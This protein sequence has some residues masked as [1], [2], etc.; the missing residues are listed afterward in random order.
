MNI[1]YFLQKENISTLWDVIAYESIFKFLPRDYQEKIFQ[2][3][4]NNIKG[5]FDIE[6]TKTTNLIDINKKYILLILSHI[7][8]NYTQQ[9][10]N[11]IK[12]LDEAPIKESITF[13]EIQNDR[14][15]QFEKDLTKRQEDFTN[16]N[17]IKVP[18]VPDFADKY[19]DKP[20]D[21][22][23]K[24]IKEMTSKRNY[25]V[26]QI[27][28][29]YNS[30]INQVN[31]WLKPQDTSVKSEKFTVSHQETQ[32]K[33]KYL[34]NIN[35][36]NTTNTTN[37]TNTTQLKKNVTWDDN[38]YKNDNECKKENI[39]MQIDEV[40]ESIFKKFKKIN[41]KEEFPNNAENRIHHIES[42]IISL[43]AKMDAIIEL[44]KSK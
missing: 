13:E 25:E 11:K 1:N 7:K 4:T 9:M 23:D 22:M 28:Q 12:I 14:K 10:P 44:L 3:F 18:S 17:S 27:N 6:K 19:D 24:I 8:K 31:N 21:E 41:K 20:I 15:S 32:N 35:T 26:E 43:N 16:Y 42:E 37:A 2:L 29:N 38:E 30:D 5:F 33:L 36:T 34:N 39:N 40:D